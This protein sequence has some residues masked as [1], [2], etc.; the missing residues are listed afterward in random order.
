[1]IMIMVVFISVIIIGTNV[2]DYAN[3]TD[4]YDYQDQNV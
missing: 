1:M 2:Y 4:H 3:D